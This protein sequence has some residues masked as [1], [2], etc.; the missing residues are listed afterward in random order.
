MS[1]AIAATDHPRPP[2]FLR[3]GKLWHSFIG[4]ISGGLGCA[5]GRPGRLSCVIISMK[6]F[7]IVRHP[8]AYCDQ[9]S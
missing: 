2:R 6:P 4:V 9:T 7:T 3:P 1:K 5:K 8:L